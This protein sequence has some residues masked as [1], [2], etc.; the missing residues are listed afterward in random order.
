MSLWTW[1]R[2]RFRARQPTVS[3]IRL[4]EERGQGFY[5]YNGKLYQ[6]DIVRGA[7][8]PKVQ[9]IGKLAARHIRETLDAEGHR[10]LVISPEPYLRFLLEEPNPIMTGQMLQERLAAQLILNSNAFAWIRRG[11]DGLPAEIWPLA[12]VMVEPLTDGAEL[13]LRFTLANLK[14]LTVPYRDVIHLRRDYNDD[15]LFGT[16]IAPALIPLM[17]IVST[18]DQGIVK[19]IKSSAV[20][21]WLLKFSN[22]LRP[23]D[24]AEQARIFNEQYLSPENETGVV[25]T[26]S[27]AEAT[28]ITQSSYVP[29]AGQ[30]DRTKERIYQLLNTNA[31]IVDSSRSEDEWNAY[32]DAEIEP[33]LIQLGQEY[34]RKI[35]SRMQRSFGNR[36]VFEA[37]SWDSASIGTKLNLLQMVDRG[38]LTPNEWRATFNLAP[39]PGGDTPVRRLDTAP[40]SNVLPE[41]GES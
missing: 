5:A 33:V 27:K 31:R 39:L 15:D 38:A 14:E 16:P 40:T 12:P 17:E 8:R 19:A 24:Q 26:D 4:I 11:P 6:S 23:E 35:F 3:G 1:L 36:I 30:M 21:R 7:M 29:N 9:A 37:S 32:F 22:S 2:A 10:T 18:T 20:I 28:P 34:T 13:R 41:G 25:V